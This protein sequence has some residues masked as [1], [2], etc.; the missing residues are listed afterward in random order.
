MRNVFVEKCPAADEG[1]P[2]GCCRA[3]RYGS[4]GMNKNQSITCGVSAAL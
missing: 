1:R 3:V 2:S 4:M